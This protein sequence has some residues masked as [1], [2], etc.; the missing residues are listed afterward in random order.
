MTPTR[1]LPRNLVDEV[2]QIRNQR[3]GDY[4][5]QRWSMYQINLQRH[6]MK[7]LASGGRQRFSQETDREWERCWQERQELI[8][9]EEEAQRAS[10]KAA[11]A[12]KD[13]LNLE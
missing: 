9:K 4:H 6:L 7:V 3:V 10:T 1:G 8:A 5:E 11:V 2:L 12:Y 13:P